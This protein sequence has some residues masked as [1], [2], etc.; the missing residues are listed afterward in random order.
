MGLGRALLHLRHER[1]LTQG[2][3]GARAGIA[4]SYVSRLENDRVQATMGTLG[5]VAEA[6]GVPLS[7]IFEVEER[8][9]QALA[10]ECPVSATGQCIGEQIRSARGRRPLGRRISYGPE[11]LRVLRMADYVV[12]HGRSSARKALAVLLEALIAQAGDAAGRR[13][14]AA[15]PDG[16]A[17]APIMSQD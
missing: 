8:G 17:P 4:A 2:Q 13:A 5:R 6:L 7:S 15:I 1:N 9:A 14:A 10:H 3:L 16:E 11:E 12:L